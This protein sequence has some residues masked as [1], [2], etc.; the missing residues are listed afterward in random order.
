MRCAIF[1]VPSTV[2]VEVIPIMKWYSKQDWVDQLIADPS[3]AN[4]ATMQ[5]RVFRQ[6]KHLFYS[7]ERPIGPLQQTS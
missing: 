3:P 4:S 1:N 7:L 6:D 5:S 2:R